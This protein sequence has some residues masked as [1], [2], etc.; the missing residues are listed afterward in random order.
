MAYY[1]G[2]GIAMLVTGLAPDVILVI[3]EITKLWNKVGPIIT[4]TVTERSL[5]HA[6]TRIVPTD[7]VL[8]PRLLGTVALVL[9]KHFGAPTVA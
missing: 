7:P 5:T 6:T 2:V 3:G 1:L 8:H 4:K 9:Q